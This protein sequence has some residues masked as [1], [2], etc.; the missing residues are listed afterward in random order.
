MLL[1]LTAVGAALAS[2]VATQ[3]I[4]GAWVDFAVAGGPATYSQSSRLAFDSQRNECVL[5]TFDG[6]TNQVYTWNGTAWT[7]RGATPFWGDSRGMAY[8]PVRDR[9]VL[10]TNS[11]QLWEWNRVA[12]QMRGAAPFPRSLVWDSAQQAMLSLDAQGLWR[13]NGNAWSLL[14][15]SAPPLLFGTS[16]AG[17]S[18]AHDAARNVLVATYPNYAVME[19]NG[20]AWAT[21]STNTHPHSIYAP[22]LGG[23]IGFAT[24]AD[25]LRFDPAQL[26]WAPLAVGGAP[27]PT[28]LYG[29]N[30]NLSLAYDSNRQRVVAFVQGPTEAKVWEYDP[31]AV[32]QPR[33]WTLGSAWWLQ[34]LSQALNHAGPGDRIVIPPGVSVSPV[35]RTITKGVHIEAPSGVLLGPDWYVRP[36]GG[37][38]FSLTGGRL[39]LLGVDSTGPFALTDC[40]VQCGTGIRASFSQLTDCTFGPGRGSCW[41]PSAAGIVIDG[42]AIVDHCTATG[43]GGY[44]HVGGTFPAQA[45]IRCESTAPLWVIHST[46]TGGQAGGWP[47]WGGG[48]APAIELQP[49]GSATVAG[50][51]TLTGAG[52]TT[53]M[54]GTADTL[55]NGATLPT[56]FPLPPFGWLS[57]PVGVA[58]GSPLTVTGSVPAANLVYLFFGTAQP[59]VPLPG[60]LLPLQLDPGAVLLAAVLSPANPSFTMPVPNLPTLRGLLT[61]WQGVDL[62]PVL[63]LTNQRAVRIL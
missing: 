46:V 2:A 61:N 41:V 7:A 59:A 56:S 53:G 17:G 5:V 22:S 43:T 42:P 25:T 3:T 26:A 45:G 54:T 23:V 37:Q 21:D 20:N 4:P 16:Y 33:T 44:Q 34:D 11:N 24:S 51:S 32:Y 1:R 47:G 58:L 6:L 63:Q 52:T 36:T 49:G 35:T 19:W 57:A 31:T 14:P 60:F 28:T 8:D 27:S 39:G 40:V 30:V 38:A 12:W 10:T 50:A 18:L 9:I 13:W 55:W 15:G 62:G 48:P 29:T